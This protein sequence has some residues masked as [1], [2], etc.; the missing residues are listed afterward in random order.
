MKIEDDHSQGRAVN[1]LGPVNGCLGPRPQCHSQLFLPGAG[2][3]RRVRAG[4]Q[5]DN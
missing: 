1:L 2:E 5:A 3:R 4:V